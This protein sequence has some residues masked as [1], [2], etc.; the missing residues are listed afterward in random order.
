MS[1]Q[2]YKHIIPIQIR[3]CDI[4][5][6][7]HVNNSVY[8]NYVELG[9][10]SYWKDVLKD[11]VNWAERGFILGRTEIDHIIP[12]HLNDEIYCCTKAIK[13][14]TKSIRFKNSIVKKVNGEFIECAAIIGILVA[15]DYV[16]NISIP[17]PE[18][19]RELMEAYER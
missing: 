2:D 1:Y 9:R 19:W 12:V 18:L 3:F 14:G 13:F 11:K 17:V 15:M 4:D 5:K 10:V 8:H 6:L 7:D 16:H